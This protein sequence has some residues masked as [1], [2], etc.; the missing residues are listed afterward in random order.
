MRLQFF[1]HEHSILVAQGVASG[2][3]GLAHAELFLVEARVG[4][5]EQ[6]VSM[7]HLRYLTL[8]HDLRHVLDPFGMHA[9]V[10]DVLHLALLVVGSRAHSHPCAIPAVAGVARDDRTVGRSFLAYHD[11]GA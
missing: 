2:D 4:S 1:D 6:A 10:V 9:S 8:H 3:S 5:V 7:A 11:A